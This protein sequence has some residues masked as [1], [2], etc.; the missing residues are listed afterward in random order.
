M[1]CAIVTS[2]IA[3]IYTHPHTHTNT[4]IASNSM[5]VT[6]GRRQAKSSHTNAHAQPYLSIFS[7]RT[8]NT[9]NLKKTT[10]NAS[11][12]RSLAHTW[13][14]DSHSIT[15]PRC[16]T[17]S[18]SWNSTHCTIR[19]VADG[20]G[21]CTANDVSFSFCTAKHQLN[22]IKKFQINCHNF[23]RVSFCCCCA[24]VTISNVTRTHAWPK[25]S[26]NNKRQ[27]HWRAVHFQNN[28]NSLDLIAMKC[29][30]VHFHL[31]VIWRCVQ[32]SPL[33]CRTQID[34]K[35]I[36]FVGIINYRRFFG[37]PNVAS[38]LVVFAIF[39]QNSIMNELEFVA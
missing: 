8:A 27:F 12:V 11:L 35:Y 7:R 13:G 20:G 29:L 23:G 2:W 30:F 1:Q 16:D 31:Y 39:H 36:S 10:E 15:L 38:T 6:Y 22:T 9:T 14:W 17:V 21:H 32:A 28:R 18:W 24:P 34:G 4:H 5:H 25:R 33:C 26:E 3:P 37:G 19:C